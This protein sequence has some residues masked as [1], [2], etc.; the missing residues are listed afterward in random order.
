MKH[1]YFFHS[2]R[3][4]NLI[5]GTKGR[6]IASILLALSWLIVLSP[7]IARADA[8][9][10]ATATVDWSQMTMT[11]TVNYTG[12]YSIAIAE[13]NRNGVQAPQV[14]NDLPAWGTVSATNTLTNTTATSSTSAGALSIQAEAIAD[15]TGA[16]LSAPSGYISRG[17][18]FTVDQA[19]N[20]NITVPYTFAYNMN[21]DTDGVADAVAA[22]G[23]ISIWLGRSLGGGQYENLAYNVQKSDTTYAE[24]IWSIS[25]SL[26]LL[27]PVTLLTGETYALDVGLHRAAVASIAEVQVPEPTTML[28]LGLGLMGLAGAR[29]F[30]KKKLERKPS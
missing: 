15:G 4:K 9:S 7:S 22:Y 24:G 12:Q 29:R 16:Y 10:L 5:F 6:N 27:A 19:F 17:A 21:M 20:F 13:A 23:Q 3:R 26:S 14:R 2:A 1:V 18:Y 11:G 30:K 25:G 28:L 8:Y